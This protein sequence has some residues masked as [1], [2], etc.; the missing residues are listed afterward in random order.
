MQREKVLSLKDAVGLIQDGDTL[1]VGGSINRRHPMAL[2][3]E[4]VRQGK[5]KLHLVGWNNASD[6]DLL[7]G[8]GCAEIVETA[9]VGLNVFGIAGNFRR[10]V[11][12]KRIR[13]V[14]QSET[15]AIDRFRAGSIGIPFIPSKTPLGSDLMTRGGETYADMTCPFTGERVAL[16]KAFTPDVAIIHA[17]SADR[18]GNVML[19]PKRMM[20][21]EIDIMIAK[22]AK[23]AIVSVEQ[24][25]SDNYPYEHPEL[26]V[27]PKVFVEAV[28]EVPYG[29]HP[30]SCDTR[31]DFD[32]EHLR[33]Y[34]AISRDPAAFQDYLQTYIHGVRDHME[35]L[36]KIGLKKIFSLTR[37]KEVR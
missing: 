12:E 4:I 36:E 34:A 24:I 35:Y 2:V 10:A 7:I 29:A 21:N 26:T 5:R 16:L 11:E 33:H 3:Y 22:S 8:A 23:K 37:P 25:V 18:L 30:T 15:T 6:F 28:V 9:Y 31:Y 17:H 19:D 1:A 27:L 14:E 13:V 20:D 32:A